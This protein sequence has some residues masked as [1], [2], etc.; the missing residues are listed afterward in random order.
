MNRVYLGNL[1]FNGILDADRTNLRT[2]ED[3]YASGGPAAESEGGLNERSE[4]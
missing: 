2:I 3:N 1:G 4:P